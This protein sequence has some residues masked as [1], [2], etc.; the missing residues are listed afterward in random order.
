MLFADRTPTYVPRPTGRKAKGAAGMCMHVGKRTHWLVRATKPK[1]Q[2][3]QPCRSVRDKSYKDFCKCCY[4][5]A[6]PP[7]GGG[8]KK[9]MVENG[10]RIPKTNQMCRECGLLLCRSCFFNIWDH[11]MKCVPTDIKL[12]F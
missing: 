6:E 11:K 3:F 12:V 5:R 10:P 4:F 9:F 8:R 1:G 7:K 2:P